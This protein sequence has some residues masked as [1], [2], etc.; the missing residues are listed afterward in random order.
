M[1]VLA[2]GKMG[3]GELNYSSD[4]DLIVLFDESRHDP[5]DYADLRR[6]FVRVTQKLV[7]LLSEPTAEGY[8]FRTDLRLRPDPSVTPVCIATDP[9]EHYY[10]SVGRTWERAAYIKARPCAG[11]IDAGWAFLDR[12]RPFVWRKHMDFW[13]I[14]DAHDMRLRIRAHKGLGSPLGGPD[15]VPGHDVKLGRGGIREIEFFTQTRQLITGGRDPDLRQRA[16][17]PAL[18]ALSSKGWVDAG[19]AAELAEAYVAHREI[20]HRLQMLDDA[21]TQRLPESAQA[22]ARLAAFCGTDV[23]TLTETLA[24][25]FARVQALTEPFFVQDRSPSAAPPAEAIFAD[26]KAARTRMA[27]WERLPAFRTERARAIFR[28]LEPE[29]LRRIAK[30]ASPDDALLSLDA[31]L[32]RLPSGVQLFSLMEAN[33]PLLDLLVDICG[34]APELARYLGR[35]AGVLDAV[36]SQDFYRPL[37]TASELRAHLAR[38]LDG[39]DDYETT[40]DTARTWMKERHF[41][42]GV[43][44]LRGLAEPEA[45]ATAYSAVADVILQALW[46]VVIA[47]FA[48]RHGPPPGAGAVIVALGKL[49]SREM[50][51]TSDL[52]L[53]VV[54]DAAGKEASEGKRPLAVTAYYARLTQALI[55]ALTAPMAEGILYKV[56][57]RL[58]PSGQSGPLATALAAFRRYQAEEAWTWEHLA[59]TR[60]RVVAGPP[61]VAGGVTAA[62]AEVLARPRAAASV[63]T[64]ATDM[65]RRLAEAHEGAAANPWEAKLGPGRMMD[66]ELLAQTGALLADLTGVRRPGQMLDRL[67]VLGWLSRPDAALLSHALDRL[68]ALQQIGRLASDHTIDPAEGG[69]GLVRLLLHATGLPDLDTLRRTLTEDAT[70]AAAII[71]ARLARR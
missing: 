2:M 54:Y 49:G 14:E 25:R 69:D 71:G 30:T 61:A 13:A 26:A 24:A 34:T 1:F 53:I 44:L 19:T 12:L 36:I 68:H 8:V 64:D 60:A 20:E 62:I 57:M 4:I 66:I 59:L 35:N 58:R 51:A 50:T 22:L 45:A 56:D 16:T 11:A 48:E 46:P 67:G 37:G 3:A 29:L 70:R 47:D 65:R 18:A 41:R 21:Q 55:A 42:I 6:G 40:L 28:R 39:I 33:P 17:L 7:K 38:R 63:L 15:D 10:E 52:D 27:A 23:A 31:F 43:H 9:A 32:G 5:D